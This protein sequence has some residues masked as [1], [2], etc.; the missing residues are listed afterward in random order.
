MS[1][2]EWRVQSKI[3]RLYLQILLLGCDALWDYICLLVEDNASSVGLVRNHTNFILLSK[4]YA[5]NCT[6]VLMLF[7]PFYSLICII[8]LRYKCMPI[9]F[10]KKNYREPSSKIDCYVTATNFNV[11]T[12]RASSNASG[13]ASHLLV[14]PILLQDKY[15]N[16]TRLF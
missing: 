11:A 1:H 16:C 5:W 7:S 10:F 14:L 6:V 8:L 3:G 9:L 4:H 2:L 12:P 15:T 13:R